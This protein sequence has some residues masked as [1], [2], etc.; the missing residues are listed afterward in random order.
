RVYR[1]YHVREPAELIRGAEMD[2]AL[3]GYFAENLIGHYLFPRYHE[4]Y[5]REQD[6]AAWHDLLTSQGMVGRG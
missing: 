3:T 4:V 5:I 6:A 2:H 1:E